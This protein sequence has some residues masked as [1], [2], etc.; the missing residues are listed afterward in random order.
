ML[1]A[2]FH[3]NI[4]FIAISFILTSWYG[5][6]VVGYL[7]KGVIDHI[8]I[9]YLTACL[10]M[11][12][13]VMLYLPFQVKKWHFISLILGNFI[14][15]LLGIFPV[16]SFEIY[17]IFIFVIALI[18]GSLV[19]LYVK[20]QMVNKEL[21]SSNAYFLL[22]VV[23]GYFYCTFPIDNI[24]SV[25]DFTSF[26]INYVLVLGLMSILLLGS[27]FMKNSFEPTKYEESK[28]EFE[29]KKLIYS[30]MGMVLLLFFIEFMFIF[31]NIFLKYESQDF[32]TMMTFPCTL[33]LILIVRKLGNPAVKY[34]SNIGWIFVF[35]LLLTFSVGMFYTFSITPIFIMCYSISIGLLPILVRKLFRFSFHSSFLIYLLVV[36]AIGCI[37]AG[38]YIENHIEFIQTIKMPK[39]VLA[40]SARQAWFKELSFL[41]ALTVIV[42]G[43]LF[44]RR[45]T[46][47]NNINIEI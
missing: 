11:C 37:I 24:F 13:A 33:L 30:A 19:G 40:L 38:Y 2:R 3:S 34:L 41:A 7:N 5:D 1:L 22:G 46:L 9:G 42:S 31:C 44:L 35:T 17:P 20:N 45:R 16:L 43:I 10:V 12:S 15:S 14:F 28:I 36:T 21:P 29:N 23:L 26:N 27:H 32:W 18:Q 25:G 39:A 47:L 6:V 4:Q 8:F